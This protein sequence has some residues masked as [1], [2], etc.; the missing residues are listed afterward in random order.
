M[1]NAS[2]HVSLPDWEK[3]MD[4]GSPNHQ[5]VEKSATEARQGITTGRV[6]WILAISTLG[7]IV[8]LAIAY[9]LT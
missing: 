1:P 4:G 2:V 6:R 9:W 3:V 5:I 7:A 8:A